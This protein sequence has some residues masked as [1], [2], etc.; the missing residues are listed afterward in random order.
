MYLAF[1]LLGLIGGLLC[2]AGDILF[3]LKGPGNKKLGTS[4][5]IDSNWTKNSRLE[6]RLVYCTC[7]CR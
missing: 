2:A 5:N 4:K 3:D 6:V 1:S 7:S